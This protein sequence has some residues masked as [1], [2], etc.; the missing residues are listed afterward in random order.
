MDEFEID[1]SKFIGKELHEF[2]WHKSYPVNPYVSLWSFFQAFMDSGFKITLDDKKR[3]VSFTEA[4]ICRNFVL[5]LSTSMSYD[6][7]LTG[8]KQKPK[9]SLGSLY[10]SIYQVYD[11]M[12]TEMMGH[13]EVEFKHN[14]SLKK[15][16][17]EERNSWN[18]LR[19]SEPKIV[20]QK[21]E[22][23]LLPYFVNYHEHMLLPITGKI[24]DLE[25]P[26]I[27]PKLIKNFPMDIYRKASFRNSSLGFR[28][29]PSE[30]TLLEI[31]F[32]DFDESYFPSDSSMTQFFF[33]KYLYE[34]SKSKNY[35][36]SSSTDEKSKL[37]DL[38]VRGYDAFQPGYLVN[39]NIEGF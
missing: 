12:E 17:F 30:E 2:A 26:I 28:Y 3:E 10:E 36:F 15:I 19:N 20:R 16:I 27:F 22:D 29:G 21:M 13:L 25:K 32:G 8:W 18:V 11:S 1:L 14:S 35:P 24:S 5:P 4:Y 34:L 37:R 31:N 6:G 38:V 33:G 23:F 9:S 7:V 39:W